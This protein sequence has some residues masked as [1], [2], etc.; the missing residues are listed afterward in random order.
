MENIKNNRVEN[1][2]DAWREK[3]EHFKRIFSFDMTTNR[4]MMREKLRHYD[5]IAVRFGRSTDPDETLTLAALRQE[6][7]H[8]AKLAY[9]YLL[10]RIVS[11]IVVRPIERLLLR[12]HF[13]KLDQVNKTSIAKEM[14][15]LGISGHLDDVKNKMAKGEKQFSVPVSYYVSE[16][17]RIDNNVV[18]RENSLG[19]YHLVSNRMSLQHDNTPGLD[20]QQTFSVGETGERLISIGKGFN[21]LEG[22][23]V[24]MDGS[25]I[26]LDLN[27]RDGS[28]NYRVKE[29]PNIYGYNLEKIVAGLG[30]DKAVSKSQ[31]EK[32]IGDL[33]EGYRCEV[34][35]NGKQF[36][37]EANPQFRT[38]TMYDQK[39]RR[40]PKAQVDNKT[41]A[42][43]TQ[44]IEK[45]KTVKKN[46]KRVG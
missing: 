12:R 38:V 2:I 34:P 28:G 26:A 23:A 43:A 1:A 16:D 44:Q 8:L 4:A 32:L 6:R 7:K 39:M 45:P 17:K 5:S 14:D 31:L 18:F 21:L 20:K 36:F 40:L 13:S 35:I 19:Q 22:R 11:N 37:I 24:L 15:Q 46:G 30:I 33:K 3:E 29:F 42:A 25:W 41:K 9:R 10:T 27:N